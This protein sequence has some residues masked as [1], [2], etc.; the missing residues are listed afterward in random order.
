MASRIHQK[1]EEPEPE[2]GL[3]GASRFFSP[4]A[5]REGAQP[6]P[7]LPTTCGYRRQKDPGTAPHPPGPSRGDDT[8]EGPGAS[9]PRPLSCSPAQTKSL[10][11]GGGGCAEQAGL[12]P[13]PER[14][15]PSGH[16]GSL[17]SLQRPSRPLRLE[18]RRPRPRPRGS[19]SSGSLSRLLSRPSLE[20]LASTRPRRPH[21]LRLRAAL[22]RP[23]AREPG[24]RPAPAL[25]RR[26]GGHVSRGVGRELAT[27]HPLV[28]TWGPWSW[29]RGAE[30][31][32]GL[33]RGPGPRAPPLPL[34]FREPPASRKCNALPRLSPTQHPLRPGRDHA[35]PRAA[36]GPQR[37][38]R[39]PAGDAARR[40]GARLLC[41]PEEAG[42]PARCCL[43]FVIAR[44]PVSPVWR[45]R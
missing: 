44:S 39:G 26:S 12:P 9:P 28:P 11:P 8:G 40:A 36:A 1:A 30:G 29:L 10:S 18:A 15:R 43:R 5:P 31:G 16:T 25:T 3:G 23:P 17:C 22:G 38:P 42:A 27:P 2:S 34:A 35:A 33:H 41:L 45:W 14:T 6:A 32:R 7:P 21:P 24:P 13:S 37:Y 19:R 4:P 20:P